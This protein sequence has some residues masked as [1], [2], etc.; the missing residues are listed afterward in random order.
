[1]LTINAKIHA[2]KIIRVEIAPNVRPWVMK[3][4][5]AVRLGLLEIHSLAAFQTI[6]DVHRH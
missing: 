3:C 1:V 4:S 6:W 5:A 2:N